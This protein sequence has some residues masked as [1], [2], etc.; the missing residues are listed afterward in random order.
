METTIL[1]TDILTK[2]KN[3]D[4]GVNNVLEYMG[5]TFRV[6]RAYI[7][8]VSDDGNFMNN[9]YEWCAPGIEPV[10][11]R[12][13]NMSLKKYGYDKVFMDSGIFASQDVEM[14]PEVTRDELRSQGVKAIVQHAII[15][16]G[17]FKGFVGFDDCVDVRPDWQPDS[18][19]CSRLRY[20]SSLLS[21]YLIKE[22]SLEKLQL[23]KERAV[24]A[25]AE[26]GSTLA[27]E[28]LDLVND[29]IG[30]G[31][32][33]F[34]YDENGERT[35]VVWSDRFRHML[36]FENE[37]DF[38][39]TFEA[40]YSRLHP[41]DREE[42]RRR[43]RQGMSGELEYDV[44]CRVMK[45][46]GTYD[47]FNIRGKCARYANGKPRLVAGT[48]INITMAE[49]A[50]SDMNGR[51]A[52]I[53]GGIRGGLKI[54][55]MEQGYPYTYVSEEVAALQGYSV[56]ELLKVTNGRALENIYEADRAATDEIVRSQIG[57]GSDHSVKYRV[58]HR[59]GSLRWIYDFGR[60]VVLPDSTELIYSLIQD[61][62]EEE[63]LNR[64]LR[65]E[66]AQY[67]DALTKNALYTLT[68]DVTQGIVTEDFTE[69][70]GTQRLKM[71]G[72]SAPCSYDEMSEAYQKKY[73]VEFFD[74]KSRKIFSREGLLRMYNEGLTSD[75]V[76]YYRKA[77]NMYIRVLLLLSQDAETGHVFATI[78]CFDITDAKK[79]TLENQRALKDALAQ[80]RYANQAK[81]TFLSN[82]SHDIR[83]PMNAIIG[84]T[85]LAS[86]HVDNRERVLDYLRKIQTSSSHLLS[87]INDILDMSR[88]ESGKV[89]IEETKISLP[90]VMHDIKNIVQTD[91]HAKRLELFF[92]TVDVVNED[93]WCDR[94]R[95]SQILLNCMS[96]AIKFTPAGGTV[97]IK[98]I[99]IPCAREGY[100]SYKFKIKDTGIGIGPDFIEHIFEMFERERS[101]T[102]SGIQGA[103][104]GM[105]ITKN[106]VDMMGGT[107]SV[108]SEKNKGSEFTISLD[109]RLAME[110]EHGYLI[111]RLEGVHALVADD[112]FDTCVSVT[113]MLRKI[114]LRPVW[115]LSGKEAVLR[116]QDELRN[117]DPFGVY[118]IDW[119]MPDMNGVE[120]VRHIRAA[121]GDEAPIIILTAYDWSSI[122]TEAREA[123]VTAFCS[124][125]LF[126][127]ELRGLLSSAIGGSKPPAETQTEKTAREQSLK[128][129]K[130]LLVE[131]NELNR[132][133]A[134]EV[135]GE[136][137]A[138]IDCAENGAVAVGKVK[139][140]GADGYDAIMM[141][142]QMP[143]MNGYEATKQIRLI[144]PPGVHIP[145]IAMTA[146]AFEEDR[147]NALCAGMDGYVAKPFTVAGV[148]ETIKN[149]LHNRVSG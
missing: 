18:K 59:D 20:V 13:Q 86:T 23:A 26:K 55:T 46:D 12:L 24:T 48:F 56:K 142:V 64:R 137:G 14:L 67:R 81:T 132:E 114:G 6:S 38:P 96:N 91:V 45:K 51:M 40:W 53:L 111:P 87:L 135:L 138:E 10:I 25:E 78:I 130:L 102:V 108:V 4:E 35:N 31:M 140:K 124:K 100:A 117:S 8:E 112:N 104:L 133:I 131:D 136:L 123:G 127:S 29:I 105:A 120:V 89:K 110:T 113:G 5:K 70:G 101:S 60:K 39:N 65:G 42:I 71:L 146:N 122:E 79:V 143:V 16:H 80:A 125:P 126:M 147:E 84:F 43:Y 98:V 134:C 7:F 68:F 47:W 145:I 77:T 149:A 37:N 73:Q 2:A 121:I 19:E 93:V 28:N 148:V 41:D 54:S 11:T 139:A 116:A 15:E 82:M 58:R 62:T 9:T 76:E 118:I 99:Q 49:I 57:H 1:I 44:K 85:A 107:I 21:M 61:V 66:Q 3:V 27:Q 88:I 103:G 34:S 115:T 97:G 95:L 128:G 109:L 17:T 94:L 90:D 63:K 22:R 141:D 83:T 106:I 144:S 75:N 119:L 69:R 50:A 36:G 129:L 92:D 33:Y 30:S 32:W 74:E 72:L 52:A